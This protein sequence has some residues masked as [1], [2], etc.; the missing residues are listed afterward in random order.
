MLQSCLEID[1]DQHDMM[2]EVMHMSLHHLNNITVEY[3]M[4][5]VIW[6]NGELEERF[7]HQ[8]THSIVL[9]EKVLINAANGNA[10]QTYVDQLKQTP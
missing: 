7:S 6:Y 3:I 5:P 2:V 8:Q 10:Y 4:K 1:G 9:V